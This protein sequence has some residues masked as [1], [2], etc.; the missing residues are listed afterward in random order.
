[1]VRLHVHPPIAL[2]IPV[3]LALSAPP[4]YYPCSCMI[5]KKHW[6]SATIFIATICLAFSAALAPVYAQTTAAAAPLN[7]DVLFSLMNT[8]RATLSLPPFQKNDQLC[9][10]ATS[11][12]PEAATEIF[13]G[14]RMHAGFWSRN[15]P[16]FATENMIYQQTE[17]A[18]LN[19]WLNS[20]IHRSA[21]DGNYTNSCVACSGK[22]CVAIFTSFVPRR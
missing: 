9:S 12:A 18:A 21:V 5:K 22:V 13:S 1:M 19:W 8:Q 6:T 16:Y 11:R 3:E 17:Q 4:W 14:G 15:L 20:P 7:A 10:V 2:F